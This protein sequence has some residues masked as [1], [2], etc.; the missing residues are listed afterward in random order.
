MK[1][2]NSCIHYPLCEGSYLEKVACPDYKQRSSLA[3]KM[4]RSEKKPQISLIPMDILRTFIL[5]AY[6]EGVIKYERESWRRGFNVMEMVDAANRHIESFS[7]SGED[8]DKEAWE[9]FGIMK[10]HLAGA[11]FSLIS[12][13][14][15]LAYHPELDD[16]K[17]PK[18]GDPLV[19]D[20]YRK[21][22]VKRGYLNYMKLCMEIECGKKSIGSYELQLPDEGKNCTRNLQDIDISEPPSEK[23]NS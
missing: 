7:H 22:I 23:Q 8:F 17:D 9:K 16:R 19:C 20:E 2:C 14:H 3:P 21:E 12:I 5:P 10:H 18:N 6:E 15:T 13:L 4:A 11:I 1:L